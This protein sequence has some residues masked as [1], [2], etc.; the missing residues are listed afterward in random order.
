MM[1]KIRYRLV[2]NRARRLNRRGEGLVQIEMEQ[3]G[4]RLYLS[5]HTYL[6]PE[7]WHDGTVGDSH[8]HAALV[9]AQL[10]TQRMEVERVELEYI[11]RGVSPTIGMVRDAIREKMQPGA[12]VFDFIQGMIAEP[13][14]RKDNT[15]AGYLTL[16]NSLQR[17]RKNLYV[18]DVDTTLISRYEAAMR[19]KGLAHNTIVGR[20]RQ[21][22]AVMNEAVRRKAVDANPFRQLPHR[23]HGAAP[24]LPHAGTARA[25]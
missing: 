19:D 5:T 21:L 22:R 8:P 24:W 14:K 23:P 13:G 7:H 18:T 9:N 15:K 11:R 3:G 1:K 25:A 6:K 10:L 16:A 20:L 17:W 2:F 12:K 4:R